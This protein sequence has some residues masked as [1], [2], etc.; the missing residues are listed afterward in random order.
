MNGFETA[1]PE[2]ISMGITRLARS[3]GIGVRECIRPE[4]VVRVGSHL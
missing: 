3:G 2:G 4:A 1:E